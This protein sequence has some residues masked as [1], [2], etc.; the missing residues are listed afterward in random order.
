[1]S[2]LDVSAFDPVFWLHHCNVDRLW[3]IWGAL[4]PNSYVQPGAVGRDSFIAKRGTI[5]D[6]NTQLKPFW[7]GSGTKFWNSA[8][9]KETTTFNYAYPETQKW[10]FANIADYQ[11]NIRSTVA[12]LYG[13]GNVVRDFIASG[14]ISSLPTNNLFATQKAVVHTGASTNSTPQAAASVRQDQVPMIPVDND[15]GPDGECDPSFLP[16]NQKVIASSINP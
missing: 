8:G 14:A 16:L 7:D 2:A 9:V 3:A 1:M 10:R 12:Q 4:N 5:E 15:I 11:R 13:T 6:V